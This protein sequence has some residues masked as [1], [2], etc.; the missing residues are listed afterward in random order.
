[1]Q[2]YLGVCLN[3]PKSYKIHQ[4]VMNIVTVSTNLLLVRSSTSSRIRQRVNVTV[5]FLYTFFFEVLSVIPL[6]YLYNN[7]TALFPE[8][9]L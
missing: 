2:T 3:S 8:S 9:L 4:K 6:K 7:Y 1:M 5:D